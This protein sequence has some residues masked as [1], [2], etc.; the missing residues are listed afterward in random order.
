M[1]TTNAVVLFGALT[2]AQVMPL[3]APD[4]TYPG[5]PT[6][7]RVLVENRGSQQTIPVSVQQIAGD[8]TMRVQVV[9]T[10]SVAIAAPAVL[11]TRLTR[12]TWEYQRIVA[13][14]DDDLTSELNRH[15]R[16]GW[17]PTLQ[18]ITPRGSLVV[19]LKR[20]R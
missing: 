4:Q 7:A 1:T 5:Q 13:Q 9:G 11:D 8:A 20:P 17:A 19:V 14:P 12:Q 18:Y 2:I 15:G 6:Q 16:D 3:A 10:P